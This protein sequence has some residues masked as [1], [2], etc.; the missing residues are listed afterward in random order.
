MSSRPIDLSGSAPAINDRLPS[1][2]GLRW[3]AAFMVFAMH[4]SVLPGGN[5]SPKLTFATS[6][7]GAVGVSFFF[8]LSGFVLTWS[9]RVHDTAT[10]FWRRRFFKI[11]PNHLVTFVL[12]A[13]IIL[14]IGDQI[15]W[16][17]PQLDSPIPN[18]LLLQAWSPEQTTVYGFNGVAWTLSVEAVFYLCFPLIF[19]LVR[20]IR[21]E[22]LW[23]WVGG[24]IAAVFCVPLVATLLPD[25]PV[26]AWLGVSSWEYW[27]VSICPAV[28]LLEFVLGVLLARIVVTGRWVKLPLWLAVVGLAGGYVAGLYAGGQYGLVAATIIPLAALIPAAAAADLDGRRTFLR[29]RAMVWLGTISFAFYLLHTFVLKIQFYL[30]SSV[31][32]PTILSE[33]ST[34]ALALVLSA[35]VAWLLFRLVE[36]PMQR[37]FSVRRRTPADRQATAPTAVTSLPQ[38]PEPAGNTGEKAAD[39]AA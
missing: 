30:L 37:R 13:V 33:V 22:R 34:A 18:L 19:M 38:S 29:N 32:S 31:T 27:F 35:L 7:S 4:F 11:Y 10:A 6:L 20:K 3:W 5:V 24:V 17:R 1:L 16:T 39:P 14:W 21:P 2:T 15:L 12:A 36:K 8:V 28:R 23:F 26:L 25:Q 9:A